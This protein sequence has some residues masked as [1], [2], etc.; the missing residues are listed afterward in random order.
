ML[1]TAI[2]IASP[3]ERPTMVSST[4]PRLSR[5]QSHR[6]LQIATDVMRIQRVVATGSRPSRPG[7]EPQTRNVV[8]QAPV[9]VPWATMVPAFQE[10][11]VKVGL[12]LG[13]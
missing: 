12:Y 11:F 8:I 2:A 10:E 7:M 5:E 6:I 13:A 9:R 3:R 4:D 1:N